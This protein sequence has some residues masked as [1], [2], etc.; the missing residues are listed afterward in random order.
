M[1]DRQESIV[2][3]KVVAYLFWFFL[4]MLGAH[5]IWWGK[6]QS[7]LAMI[8]LHALGWVLIFFG[9]GGVAVGAI[10]ESLSAGLAGGGMILLAFGMI[11][12]A[13]IWW[14]LDAVLI[15]LWGPRTT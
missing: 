10:G 8:A 7:A 11:G 15:L 2:G 5:R 12:V 1:A 6:W 13:W 9:M 14:A 3:D 4:G